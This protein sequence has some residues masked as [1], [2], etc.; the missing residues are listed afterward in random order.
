MG[1]LYGLLNSERCR[2]RQLAESLEK[3]AKKSSSGLVLP[4]FLIFYWSLVHSLN[5]TKI[6]VS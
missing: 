6:S 4:S 1:N 3:R 5:F 2:R